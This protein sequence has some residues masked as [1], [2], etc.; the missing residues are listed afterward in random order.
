[1]PD[2]RKM[3]AILCRA[4]DAVIEPLE[5]FPETQPE[6]RRLR[7]A[8]LDAEEVYIA[9]SAPDPPPPGEAVSAPGAD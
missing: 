7:R 9:S 4:I 6:A 1:M 2:Y 5:I 8:L 3:Y